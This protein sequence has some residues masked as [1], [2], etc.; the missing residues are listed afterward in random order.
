MKAQELSKL[1]AVKEARE[2]DPKRLFSAK[3]SGKRFVEKRGILDQLGVP[4]D[5]LERNK[6]ITLETVKE[7]IEKNIKKIAELQQGQQNLIRNLL[8]D[9][10]DLSS[11]VKELGGKRPDEKT[12]DRWKDFYVDR[13]QQYS[14]IMYDNELKIAAE[15]K[16]VT[17]DPVSTTMNARRKIG[18]EIMDATRVFDPEKIF[19]RK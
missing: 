18:G 3:D 19:P 12:M 17:L 6:Q 2:M 4:K 1:D 15:L 7:G 9:L 8:N 13:I 16:S 11:A 5:N 14:S 10:G